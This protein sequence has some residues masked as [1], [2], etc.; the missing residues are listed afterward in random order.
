[1]DP[2]ITRRQ[3]NAGL[4]A[5]LALVCLGCERQPEGDARTTSTSKR[6][7]RS[8]LAKEPFLIGPLA[9]YQPPGVYEQFWQDKDVYLVSNGQKLIAIASV[10]T[11]LG[12][13]PYWHAD[14]ARFVCPCHKSVFD[15]QGVV[16]PDMKAKRSLDRCAI[17]LVDSPDGNGKVVQVDPTRLFRENGP[18]GTGWDSPD[19]SLTLPI[20]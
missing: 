14:E 1:M 4:G 6:R 17:H 8:N 5:T 2:K 15:P 7:T 19:A 9:Q 10:C 18:D 20:T 3:F 12:C 16:Q 11:H 13:T